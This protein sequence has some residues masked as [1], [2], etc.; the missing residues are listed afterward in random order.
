M[1]RNEEEKRLILYIY[2]YIRCHTY[3]IISFMYVCIVC[4]VC[5]YV[6]YVCMMNPSHYIHIKYVCMY[7]FRISLSFI[8]INL[9]EARFRVLFRV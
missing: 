6:L 1:R 5:M 2:V 3:V 4:I 9:S 7:V 8:H